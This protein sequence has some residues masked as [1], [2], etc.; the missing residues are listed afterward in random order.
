MSTAN[1]STR[2]NCQFNQCVN[3]EQTPAK[4]C[5]RMQVGCKG[6]GKIREMW[7]EKDGARIAREV[8]QKTTERNDQRVKL[9]N[10]VASEWSSGNST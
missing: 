2:S 9:K 5:R 1:D 8:E 10:D 3:S 6:R 7:K 4:G